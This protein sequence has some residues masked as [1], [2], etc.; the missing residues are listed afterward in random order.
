MKEAL[1][2]MR[3]LED[4]RGT[5]RALWQLG[6][7]AVR[8]GDYEQAVEYFDMALPLLRQEGDRAHTAIALT[9]LAEV[10]LR[11]GDYER[12]TVLEEE[13]LA[14]RREIGETWGIAVSLG[15]FAWNALRRDDLKQA[16]AMLAESLTL[17]RE[18]GDIGGAAWCLEKFAEIAQ[19]A[20]QSA[21]SARRLMDS[22]RAAKLFG[23]AQSLPSPIGSVIDLADQPG[24][25][26]LVAAVRA[27]L[28]E[29]TFISSWEEGGAMDLDEAVAYSLEG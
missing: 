10:A 24:Y 16:Q 21:S 19:L 1:V 7:C 27:Q 28:D 13:S 29:Q 26:R 4:V 11:Q 9:G 5:A 2:I 14:L 23:A 12:A 18:I 3:D 22:R 8:P 15:N 6:Q 25:E 20:G 17:R